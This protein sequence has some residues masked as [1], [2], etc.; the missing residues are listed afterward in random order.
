LVEVARRAHV[1]GAIMRGVATL[2]AP[3]SPASR[4]ELVGEMSRAISGYLLAFEEDGAP[5]IRHPGDEDGA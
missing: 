2:M 5:A 1:L 4:R 3:A